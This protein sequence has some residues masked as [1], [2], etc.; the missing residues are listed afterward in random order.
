VTKQHNED[1]KHLL[2][3]MGVPVVEAPSEAEGQC[4]ELARKGKV[5]GVATEDMDVLTFRTP[6]QLKKLTM[7][8]SRK[9]PIQ[10]IEHQKILDGF[11]I[12]QAQ[13]ID[14]CILCG[15]DYCDSIKGIGP[16]KALAG[17]KKYGTIEKFLESMDKDSKNIQIPANWL[18]EE[19]IFVEARRIFNELE[20]VDAENLDIK[21]GDCDEKALTEFL[22]EKNGFNA[23]RVKA[24]I[25]RLKKAKTK[26]GQT[27]MDSFFKAKPLSETEKKSL[28]DKKRKAAG[29][30][31]KDAAAA[32]KKK[33]GM[34]GKKK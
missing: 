9:E 1:V 21:W 3:L 30:K 2:R 19:P 20:V 34:F 26:G 8:A 13:F 15:C 24:A 31:K 23:E 12:T 22:V 5:W 14:L 29:D 16:K 25:E 27:R 10:L 32:K 17:I 4:A 6:Y 33:T 7:A 28:S 18:T 11:G